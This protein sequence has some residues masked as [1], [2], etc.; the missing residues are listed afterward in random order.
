MEQPR[1]H[2]M[3]PNAGAAAMPSFADALEQAR[4]TPTVDSVTACTLFGVSEYIMRTAA[5]KGQFGAIRVGGRWRFRSE[6]VL[7]AI[8]EATASAVAA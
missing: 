3:P 6:L 5:N 4:K 8:G 1:H 7:A 2:Q